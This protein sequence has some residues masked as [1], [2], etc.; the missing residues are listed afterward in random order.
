M[1]A[2]ELP[3]YMRIAMDL[4][5]RIAMGEFGERQKITGRSIL[6]S[7]Y[8]VSPETARKA[9]RL[10]A[11]MEVVEI[12][13][14]SG[15]IVNS[16]EKAKQYLETFQSQRE[17]QSL[18]KRL[19]ELVDQYKAV[20][21]ELVEV[22]E[23][24][25]NASALPL[26]SERS[27]PNY[28]VQIEPHSGKLGRSIGSLHFWQATGAT[29]VAIRR[30]QNTLLSPGPYAEFCAGDIVVFVGVPSCV[31]AVQHFLNAPAQGDEAT[32]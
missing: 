14:K 13:E 8:R 17:Q 1:A 25:M 22:G 19:R 12:R 6:A 9:V 16:A 27:L 2:E 26:P 30:G 10:L 18:Q 28:E 23:R 11:D 3:Q 4:A 29:I 7:E 20:G 15:V 5:S 24:L 31:S 32:I 21:K